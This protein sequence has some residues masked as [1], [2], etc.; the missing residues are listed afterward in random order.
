MTRLEAQRFVAAVKALRDNA[1]D[2]QASLAAAVYPTLKTDSTLIPA[3]TRINWNGTI[4]RA[5]VD[6][7]DTTENN[8]D[9]APTLWEDINYR[10]GY[11]TIPEVITVGTAFSKGE[12]G[13]WKEVLYESIIDNNVWTPVSY[14]QGWKII[15]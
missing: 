5:A 15:E 9:N 13:W 8:P 1:T 7:W 11:R 6:L 10:D 14:P 2:A 4:K 3:G 12:R